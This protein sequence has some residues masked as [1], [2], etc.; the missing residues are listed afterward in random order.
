MANGVGCFPLRARGF[1]NKLLACWN[2]PLV[3]GFAR[4]VIS[5]DQH[6]RGRR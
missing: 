4:I 3:V 2:L 5:K 1:F 6:L